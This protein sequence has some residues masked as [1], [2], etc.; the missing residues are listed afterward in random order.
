MFNEADEVLHEDL[1]AGSEYYQNILNET[2]PQHQAVKFARENYGIEI[3]DKTLNSIMQQYAC[4]LSP[5]YKCVESGLRRA[6]L[7]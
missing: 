2:S 5:L 3:D 4:T 7:L 1:E 6:G